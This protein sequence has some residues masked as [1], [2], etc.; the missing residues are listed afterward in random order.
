VPSLIAKSPLA[1]QG[2]VTLAGITLSE[3]LIDRMTAVAPLKG[4]KTALAKALKSLGLAFPDPNRW[5]AK[6]D[7]QIVW[8]GRDQAFLIDADP[9]GLTGAALT[10]QSDGWAGITLHGAEAADM[11]MRLYPL[12]LRAA[13]FAPGHAARSP[14]GHMSSVLIRVSDD[15][16]D[17]LVFRSMAAFAW[18][19]VEEAMKKHAARKAAG[20]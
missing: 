14:L 15:R 2:P 17:L 1:G 5:L 9:A 10:D 19:E 11:L 4:G 18:H 8:T 13:V 6:G 3:R 20:C 7:A 12:D 16:F